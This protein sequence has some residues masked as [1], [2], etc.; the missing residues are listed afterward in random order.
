VFE[1]GIQPLAVVDHEKKG[2]LKDLYSRLVI[3]WW[4][5]RA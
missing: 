5:G 1:R 3:I 2:R 4:M